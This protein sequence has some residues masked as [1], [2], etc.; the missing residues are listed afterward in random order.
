M[1][2]ALFLV[3]LSGCNPPPPEI[4]LSAVSLV[5]ES[6]I[7]GTHTKPEAALSGAEVGPTFAKKRGNTQTG[8]DARKKKQIVDEGNAESPLVNS[9][10]GVFS[11]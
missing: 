9:A 6:F 2:C 7:A 3:D 4:F 5:N 10:R 8:A 1:R 11:A